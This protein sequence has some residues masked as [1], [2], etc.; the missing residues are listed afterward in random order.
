MSAMMVS[1][2]H[3]CLGFVGKGFRNICVPY[4]FTRYSLL[5]PVV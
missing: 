4:I 1:L 3:F 5:G 2:I